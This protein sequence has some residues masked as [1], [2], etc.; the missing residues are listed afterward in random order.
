M[1]TRVDL[2]TTYELSFYTQFLSFPLSFKEKYY[3][4]QT[5]WIPFDWNLSLQGIRHSVI[6]RFSLSLMDWQ[7]PGK[8]EVYGHIRANT[9]SSEHF[10]STLKGMLTLLSS[11]CRCVLFWHPY[12]HGSTPSQPWMCCALQ[13]MPWYIML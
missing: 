3:Q 4:I 2:F 6:S 12:E 11:A 9:T 1:Y 5:T 10:F 8:D 13:E 7:R